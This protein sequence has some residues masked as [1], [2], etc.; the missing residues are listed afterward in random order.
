MRMTH[1]KLSNWRNF[2][3]VDVD[4]PTRLFVLGPNASGKSNLLDAV[5]FLRDLTVD[6]GGF[7]QAVKDRGGL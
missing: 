1:L 2:K 4:V 6:G 7:Q 5:R 3:T